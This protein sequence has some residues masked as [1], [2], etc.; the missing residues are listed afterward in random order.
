[1]IVGV[2][3]ADVVAGDAGVAVAGVRA[4]PV[5]SAG[6]SETLRTGVVAG[7]G[8]PVARRSGAIVYLGA[9]AD[10]GIN[11]AISPGAFIV[12]VLLVSSVLGVPLQSVL[13]LKSGWS[14][15]AGL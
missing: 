1:M 5:V 4:D 12:S 11:V 14:E 13:G 6:V 9:V 8:V 10:I 7:T 2:F 3:F 15:P